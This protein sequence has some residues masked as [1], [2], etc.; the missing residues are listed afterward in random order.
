MFFLFDIDDTLYDLEDPFRLAFEEMFPSEVEDIHSIFLDFRKYNNMVYE[1]AILGEITMEEMCIYRAKNAFRDHNI[2]ISDSEALKFQ[3][4]YL[5]K[6]KFIRLNPYVQ[7]S[8]KL[9]SENN[10]EMGLVS[11][12]PHKEQMQKYNYLGLK[13]FIKKKYTFISEDVGFY[14]P[15]CRILK[16]ACNKMNISKNDKVFFI[17]D[18]IKLD[19]IPAK[20]YGLNTIWINRR[21]YTNE[22]SLYKPDY[23]AYSFKELYTIIKKIV[24]SKLSSDF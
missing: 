9:L 2:I 3:L 24:D 23:I 12:G 13:R 21:N 6:K 15:D 17:G 22:S 7:K 18:S 16:F 8:L 19:I 20:K 4:L 5:S 11:N 14:K 10:I 1:K